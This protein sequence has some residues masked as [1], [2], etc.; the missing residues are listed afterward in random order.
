MVILIAC[1]LHASRQ[2]TQASASQ[3]DWLDI[4]HIVR[5]QRLDLEDPAFRALLI[6]YGSPD[7]P[8]ILS[9]LLAGGTGGLA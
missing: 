3:Q 2:R 9:R 7:T 1:K 8:D 6:R 4:A 5:Q